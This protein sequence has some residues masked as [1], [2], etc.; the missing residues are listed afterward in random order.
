MSSKPPAPSMVSLPPM[1]SKNSGLSPPKNWSPKSLPKTPA[2][3][4]SL[5]MPPR[6]SSA[7]P[8]SPPACFVLDRLTITPESAFS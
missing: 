3:L 2:I 1:G 4:I 5:S 6:P 7:V 8:G